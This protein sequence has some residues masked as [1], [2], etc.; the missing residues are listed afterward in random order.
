MSAASLHKDPSGEVVVVDRYTGLARA[1]HWGT[2]ISLILL[3]LSGMSLFHPALFFLTALFGGGPY[4]RA[5]HPWFGAVLLVSFAILFVRFFHHNLW[6]RED[7]TWV[8]GIRAVITN[9]EEELP[10]VGRYNAAQKL[11][12]WSMSLLILVLFV[13]GVVIWD[14]YFFSFTSIEIKRAA[15]LIHSL[16]AVA[17]IAVWISHVYAAIWVRGSMSGMMRG[18]V[19]PGWTF[20]HHRKWLRALARGR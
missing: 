11:V 6:T 12:F 3:A 4:T 10:E 16:A 13:S 9:R 18:T 1:N 5:I 17:I 2:A 20:R 14:Q 19:T 7:T 8:R 15:V